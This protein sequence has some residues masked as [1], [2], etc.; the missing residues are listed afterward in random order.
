MGIAEAI[1][2]WRDLY[3][4]VANATAAL[5]GLVFVGMSLHIT[6]R[7]AEAP[8]RSLALASAITLIQP[9]LVSFV[10]L[11]PTGAPAVHAAGVLVIAVVLVVELGIVLRIHRRSHAESTGWL[12]YRFG[13]PFAA[14][15]VLVAGAIG[16]LLDWPPSVWAPAVFVFATVIVGVQDAWDLL[17]SPEST[18]TAHR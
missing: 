8:T 7:R 18:P 5:L 11:I 16:M 4:A 9:L 17:I 2:L 10:M 1:E 12:A 3:G 14:S 15:G 13:I 6:L